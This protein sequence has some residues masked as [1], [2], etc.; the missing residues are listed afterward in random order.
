MKFCRHGL[1]SV[2]CASGYA[3]HGA[4]LQ[5]REAPEPGA[6]CTW[7]EFRESTRC[8]CANA[9][10]AAWLSGCSLGTH[11]YMEKIT[12]CSQLL[13]TSAEGTWDG[14]W[15]NGA[16]SLLEYLNL[17]TRETARRIGVSFWRYRS[18]ARS[19]A[20]ANRGYLF[21]SRWERLC[22]AEIWLGACGQ[23]LAGDVQGQPVSSSELAIPCS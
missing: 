6:S 23:P 11:G 15:G 17:E 5:P 8:A 3:R 20:V 16:K 10:D 12:R 19:S 14:S 9:A 21:L 18:T 2:M 7:M 13:W 22:P 1:L 4:K